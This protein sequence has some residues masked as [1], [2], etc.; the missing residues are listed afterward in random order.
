MY[1]VDVDVDLGDL[2]SG[3]PLDGGDDV[4]ADRLGEVCQRHPVLGDDLQ[5]DGRL[6]LTDFDRHPL[7]VVGAGAGDALA[8][9]AEMKGEFERVFAETSRV[10]SLGG[11]RDELEADLAPTPIEATTDDPSI[12]ADRRIG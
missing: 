3:H 10:L 12:A 4:A 9:V 2:Q 5:V 8:K 7:G 11:V 6:S 1:V